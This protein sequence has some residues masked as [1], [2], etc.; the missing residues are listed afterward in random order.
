WGADGQ[1]QYLGRADEQVKIRGFRIELGEVQ[2]ALA[3]LDGVD[4]AV[5]IARE[6][7][8][9]DKRLVGYV[10]GAA[11]PA[12]VRTALAE[13]L[14]DYMVPAAVVVVD[15]LPLTVNGKLDTRALPAPDYSGAGRY[16][17]PSTA[18]EEILAGIYARVLG[19]E[20]VGVDEPFFDLGGNSLQAM[21]VV[22]AVQE[23][24]D[25]HLTVRHLF[26]APTVRGLSQRLGAQTPSVEV[27]SVE[28]LKHG[29]GDPLFCIHTVEGLAWPYRALGS[30]LACPIIGIQQ[31]PQSDGSKPGS[32]RGMA[33]NY[34]DML[35][36]FHPP[37][38]YNLLGWSFG[39][40]VGH[41]L[42]IE[43]RRRGCVV[44]R[45]IVLD[46]PARIDSVVT[47]RNEA[48]YESN[49]LEEFLRANRIDIP[50]HSEPLTYQEAE[51]LI[52]ERG[53]VE[54][55]LPSKQLVDIMVKNTRTDVL[56]RS[57]HVPGVF[58][59]DM[60]VFAA[61][62]SGSGISLLQSWRPYVAGDITEYSVDCT[63]REMLNVE[64]LKLFGEQLN[65]ALGD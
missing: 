14:P 59:G 7:H 21:R 32:V 12:G 23:S 11:D 37:G 65:V 45:L 44:R 64:V 52:H 38:P 33:K 36:V 48:W 49:I 22:A 10:T 27:V 55:A 51:E 19:V 28:M 35:Q 63:H 47:V 31:V 50:K 30:Y 46:A 24:L 39:G 6:D 40:V 56:Y 34:A 18:V 41:E 16:R 61:T 25:A 5:V 43:L 42:A 58:D 60:I 17:A 2:A 62:R 15:E 53:A 3:G 9:G 8:P 13:R 54:A 4:N 57:E 20:R 1:L 26:D 29:T